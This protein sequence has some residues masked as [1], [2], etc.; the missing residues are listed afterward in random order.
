MRICS[1]THYLFGLG[2]QRRILVVAQHAVRGLKQH[3]IRA[4]SG[5]PPLFIPLCLPL[6]QIV[7]APT[8]NNESVRAT[9]SKFPLAN[10]SGISNVIARDSPIELISVK[11]AHDVRRPV[12]GDG[13]VDAPRGQCIMHTRYQ[14]VH[15]LDASIDKYKGSVYYKDAVGEIFSPAGRFSVPVF[16]AQ[17]GVDEGL[18]HHG[19]QGPAAQARRPQRRW[20]EAVE[21]SPVHARKST[22]LLLNDDL[23]YICIDQI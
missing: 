20:A 2:T 16:G 9:A 1:I 17:H 14:T 8:A 3:A 12:Q 13:E 5:G 15:L 18:V 6:L 19:A 4:W 21:H 23:R 7:A 22:T 10:P 11:V